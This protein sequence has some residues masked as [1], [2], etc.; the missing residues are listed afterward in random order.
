MRAFP[1]TVFRG[2]LERGGEPIAQLANIDVKVERVVYAKE[3]EAEADAPR[4]ET[5]DYIL[6]GHPADTFLAHRIA[7]A[8]DFDQLLGVRLVDH[9]LTT[10][11][12]AQGVSIVLPGRANSAADRL[13][14]GETVSA[15]AKLAG[16][17][18]TLPVE[19]EV[20][21]EYYFEES[22]L[23]PQSADPFGQTP[24]EQEAGF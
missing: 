6:F 17:D 18:A 20:T 19:V 5:L 11:D 23:D 22:E 8:P 3:I 7:Q 2:H 4:S 15:Q 14:A 12:L 21:T 1:A 16:S 10:D 9:G 13:R 24:R